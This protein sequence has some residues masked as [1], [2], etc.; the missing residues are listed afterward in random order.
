VSLLGPVWEVSPHDLFYFHAHCIPRCYF[1]G[2]FSLLLYIVWGARN[3][4]LPSPDF[5]AKLR[6]CFLVFLVNVPLSGAKG[7]DGSRPQHC[8]PA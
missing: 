4:F 3:S 1:Q 5:C 6:S 2:P 8:S 7:C